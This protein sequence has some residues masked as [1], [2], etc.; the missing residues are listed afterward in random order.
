MSIFKRN[1]KRAIAILLVVLSVFTMTGVYNPED[2]KVEAAGYKC[3]A[4][5]FT[6][7]YD[8]WYLYLGDQLCMCAK[9]GTK[10]T[11]GYLYE[12]TMPY[13]GNDLRCLKAAWWMIKSKKDGALS[14]I[15]SQTRYILGRLMCWAVTNGHYK[16]ADDVA[17]YVNGRWSGYYN[18]VHSIV[19]RALSGEFDSK[20]SLSYYANG[21]W[22]PLIIGTCNE[23]EKIC[24]KIHKSSTI[25]GGVV[26]D[27][28]YGIY[29]DS[30]CKTKAIKTIKTD[31]SGNASTGMIL[32][33]STFKTNTTYYI[34]ET[35]APKGT[36]L[37]TTIYSLKSGGSGST[38][39]KDVT[40][41]P[42]S[43]II[44]VTK[45]DKASKAVLSGA[46]FTIKEWN[47]NTGKWVTPSAA[48]I[49]DGKVT[50]TTGS[51]GQAKTGKLYYTKINQGK[52]KIEE[53]K[54]PTNYTLSSS[55][56]ATYTCSANTDANKSVTFYDTKSQGY[57]EVQK[58]PDEGNN[59]I[60]LTATFEI[61]NNA[62]TTKLQTLKTNAKGYKK[63]SALDVGTYQL[64]E[65]S[66]ANGTT[67]NTGKWQAVTVTA[68][69]T[70]KVTT[71]I[72]IQDRWYCYVQVTK[73][74][75]EN[76][77]KVLGNAVFTVYEA[78]GTGWKKHSTFT[79]SSSTG[80]GKSGKLYYTKSNGGKFK[81]VETTA[82]ANYKNEGWSKEFSLTKSN[83]T[84]TFSYT[85]TNPVIKGK[86]SIQKGAVDYEGTDVTNKADFSGIKYQVKDLNSNA[87]L[88]TI[89][90]DA[91]GYGLSKELAPGSYYIQEVASSVSENFKY[92]TSKTLKVTVTSGKTT[93]Y[94]YSGTGTNKSGISVKAKDYA[95]NALVNML[96]RVE[97]NV[98]KVDGDGRALAGAKF[99]LYEWSKSQ[100][101]YVLVNANMESDESGRVQYIESIDSYFEDIFT[102]YEIDLTGLT[103]IGTKPLF[104]L[105]IKDVFSMS[106]ESM[107][108]TSIVTPS[109]IIIKVKHTSREYGNELVHYFQRS[110]DSGYLNNATWGNLYKLLYTL[111][112]ETK[113]F[114][115][116]V[117]YGFDPIPEWSNTYAEA[118]AYSGS[119]TEDMVIKGGSSSI[120]SSVF[121][122]KYTNQL[123]FYNGALYRTSVQQGV[124]DNPSA[125][126]HGYYLLAMEKPKPLYYTED[127]LGKYKLV[128]TQSPPGYD[129]ADYSKEFTFKDCVASNTAPDTTTG[130]QISPLYKGTWSSTKSYAFTDVVLY[131]GSLYQCIF[132]NS[133]RSPGTSSYVGHKATSD[134]RTVGWE[135]VSTLS[136]TSFN[137][138]YGAANSFSEGGYQ[139][140]FY[141][142]LF[143]PYTGAGA[144]ASY[145]YYC[146][147]YEDS[148]KTTLMDYIASIASHGGNFDTWSYCTPF[149][150]TTNTINT[151][152]SLYYY[153]DTVTNTKTGKGKILVRKE[154]SVN[155]KL[156]KGATFAAYKG[157]TFYKNLT[158][159]GDGTYV[160]DN[161]TVTNSETLTFEIRETTTPV[162]YVV[163]D[164]SNA[165]KQS[166]SISNSSLQKTLV[167]KE[168]PVKGKIVGRKGDA[169]ANSY[170]PS[171]DADL[172]GAVYNL[173][174]DSG[175]KSL[176]AT[177]TT[178]DLGNFTFSNLN[179][180]T[181]YVKEVEAPP[182][183]ELNDTVI[184][185]NLLSQYNSL[186][187]KVNVKEVVANIGVNEGVKDTPIQAPISIHKDS[188][189][190]D[191]EGEVSS[192]SNLQGAGFS[193]YL[194][195]K[196][197][198]PMEENDYEALLNYD[199]SKE[200]AEI[201]T[202]ANAREI[203]TDAS[204]NAKTINLPYGLYVLVETT[205]PKNHIAGAETR[206]FVNITSK[207]SDYS[208][209]FDNEEYKAPIKI[210]KVDTATDKP[211]PLPGTTFKVKNKGTG[212]YTKND[213]GTD[214]EYSVDE[215]GVAYTEDLL[216][217]TYVVSETKAVDGWANLF[218]SKEV[219]ISDTSPQ[220]LI[221]DTGVK[222]YLTK[223]NNPEI[224]VEVSKSD[225]TTHA[226]VVG[227]MMV[228]Y[229][230]FD[231]EV[232]RWTTTSTTHKIEGLPVGE[233]TLV[234]E[235]V[236]EGYV[237][238]EN[239]VFNVED[240]GSLQ[241]ITMEEDYIKLEVA[242]TDGENF[243]PGAQ[244][245]LVRLNDVVLDAEG[246]PTSY[247]EGTVIDT[248]TTDST[249]KRFD[250]IKSDWYILKELKTP[251][252]Y[253]TTEN[254]VFYVDETSDVQTITMVN[255]PIRME[256]EKIDKLTSEPIVGAHLQLKSK[257]NGAI[258][259]EWDSGEMPE[260][261]SGVPVGQ[262]TLVETKAPDGYLI[263]DPINIEIIDTEDTQSFTMEDMPIQIRIKKVDSDGEAVSGA[264]LQ[265][266]RKSDKQVVSDFT[267]DAAWTSGGVVIGPIAPGVY[268]LHEEEVP[269]GYEK[270]PDKDFTVTATEDIMEVEMVDPSM[271]LM[272]ITKKDLTTSDEVPGAKMQ[273]TKRGTSDVVDSWT[274]TITPHEIRLH[275]GDYTLTE[276]QAPDGYVTANSVDFSVTLGGVTE[277]TMYD[278][279]TQM[280][281]K[282][283]DEETG[284]PV[285][286]ATLQLLKPNGEEVF[287]FVTGTEPEYRVK[288]PVGTYTLHEKIAPPG[289]LLAADVPVVIEDKSGVQE[290]E[291]KDAKKIDVPTTGGLGTTIWVIVGVVWIGVMCGVYFIYKKRKG[292]K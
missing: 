85:V 68:N 187:S 119:G 9:E 198:K 35:S 86:I 264:R 253:Y 2:V 108:N 241:T 27:A 282:K 44:T 258:V 220:Q 188:V 115:K 176:L 215:D 273:I 184:T 283:V 268:T 19:S 275:L 148:I 32:T 39:T 244:L 170:T 31:S 77:S 57:I 87:V 140:R 137:S 158:D 104:D 51:N 236:P 228:I 155:G 152:G 63:S 123:I 110:R 202:S 199:F 20:V 125:A 30:A 11:K 129:M 207:E 147:L 61:W 139:S 15:D 28:T 73:K 267:T 8:V 197:A 193:V 219:V 254:I 102:F 201:V 226:Q 93:A 71:G 160:L 161:I 3:S 156:I 144:V 37:N 274:S 80:I 132:P 185:V 172:S 5:K 33:N 291:M 146:L 130:E 162:G 135:K 79:T 259:H 227:A 234:E 237:R 13:S 143:K 260:Q 12:T 256:V 111:V 270:A 173:Y 92:D 49:S 154:D 190:Y 221:D 45:K 200:T 88:D 238:A 218:E 10:L 64:K 118:N 1:I 22:Q 223:F 101:K 65:I 177:A 76:T 166:V 179:L 38:V 203:F 142:E 214:R 60:D 23:N 112:F 124:L 40:N 250:R 16:N 89:T 276:T 269:E 42:T 242:K 136:Y 213:D 191:D 178:D 290:F 126:A 58:A 229:D 52:W 262:Y 128:E 94:T 181:Y 182:G 54:A 72:M 233:Y 195:S 286:G 46:T 212:E 255:N 81:V 180:T 280:S 29:T 278:D 208:Y 103:G 153:S 292:S 122:T 109:N 150:Y 239:I 248:W 97:L 165:W 43:I 7:A 289:Y 272:K 117:N 277:V 84:K 107:E 4:G 247:T 98:L 261:I 287:S 249:A 113:D 252:G 59:D 279:I 99:S 141:N 47:S 157:G 36:K 167:C 69:N 67:A 91:G 196:L 25:S 106:G 174:T 75:K 70:T 100:G 56:N 149:I 48:H 222:Y 288:I 90:L 211:I 131:N 95:T 14:S 164:S 189:I 62:K 74:D 232:E 127:N 78:S 246:T 281:I 285:V 18:T 82:P 205:V 183:Y 53:T 151:H 192:R 34:K 138:M 133:N 83:T 206:K 105:R 120:V 21:S 169:K 209:S 266:I 96:I 186:S 251:A 17:N 163:L 145:D 114:T 26:K 204:G 235:S 240:T 168:D 41:T 271:V 243:V 217:G 225:V 230:E 224:Q 66:T 134:P 159:R 284:V 210:Y 265:V 175:C 194:V 24:L 231:E 245:S 263:A 121:S 257:T 171:G 6:G 116:W 216:P 50:I 55:N